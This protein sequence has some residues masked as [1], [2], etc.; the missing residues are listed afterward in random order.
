MLYHIVVAF[1]RTY[2]WFNDTDYVC[3]CLC[4]GVTHHC[5]WYTYSSPSGAAVRVWLFSLSEGLKRVR[6]LKLQLFCTL[7]GLPP[8]SS[9]PPATSLPGE[10]RWRSLI[11][12]CRLFMLWPRGLAIRTRSLKL[13]FW[14]QGGKWEVG[15]GKVAERGGGGMGTE[16]DRGPTKEA[17]MM[18]IQR[19]TRWNWG[20]WVGGREEECV[21]RESQGTYTHKEREKR[22][23]QHLFPFRDW[24]EF[25]VQMEGSIC[26]SLQPKH[27]LTSD[28]PKISEHSCRVT[29]T[30]PSQSAAVITQ[31]NL[32]MCSL[33]KNR[34]L[35]GLSAHY[36]ILIESHPS[37]KPWITSL[38]SF[39]L[40]FTVQNL[41]GKWL[42]TVHCSYT[43][44]SSIDYHL[45]ARYVWYLSCLITCHWPPHKK[46]GRKSAFI[47]I[48]YSS[49][50]VPS[51]GLMGM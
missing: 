7:A 44:V 47:Q 2:V 1:Y 12:I 4:V 18:K 41:D 5:V 43:M 9:A 33:F 22:C 40:L 21:D 19:A 35:K 31:S 34:F 45:F 10:Q 23:C 15:E 39:C 29:E 46:N 28:M 20:K 24:E 38:L 25:R 3:V 48:M 13:S 30:N 17:R 8:I 11:D 27:H 49:F 6:S 51:M 26:L 32:Y 16:E 37:K 42:Q 50:L 36:Q 14:L